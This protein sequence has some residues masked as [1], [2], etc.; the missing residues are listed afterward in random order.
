MARPGRPGGD[1][2]VGARD[3]D[4]AGVGDR[5]ATTRAQ[6]L[7]GRVGDVDDGEAA[8]LVDGEEVAEL[9]L[10]VRHVV[11]SGTSARCVGAG[12][13]EVERTT[14]RSPNPQHVAG[15]GQRSAP[16]SRPSGFQ[17][18]RALQEVVA[19]L[20]VGQR[21]DVDQDQALLPVGDRG[22]AVDR[23]SGCSR[24]PRQRGCRKKTRSKPIGMLVGRATAAASGGLDEGVLAQ[25]RDRR[26]DDALGEV[27]VV[28]VGDVE[29]LEAAWSP[30]GVEVL[31]AQLQARHLAVRDGGRARSCRR[32][33]RCG[34]SRRDRRACAGSC[35]SPPGARPTR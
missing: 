32:L 5:G 21:R 34:R 10:Q 6:V 12:I 31:A 3:V 17:R 13:V 7:G 16:S 35:R 25:G 19:R 27:L 26:G 1:V 29:D 8:P 2:G 24:Y 30:G 28:D 9:H 23:W 33:L 14:P 15:E 22:V 20:A 11:S 18:Q 4:G